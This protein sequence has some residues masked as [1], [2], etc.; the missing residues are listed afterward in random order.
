MSHL[1]I[2]ALCLPGEKL[3]VLQRRA[4]KRTPDNRVFVACYGHEAAVFST[5]ITVEVR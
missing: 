2:Q 3:P 1:P 5:S 4:Q